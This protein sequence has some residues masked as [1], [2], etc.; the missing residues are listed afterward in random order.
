M[1]TAAQLARFE[2]HYS[3]EPNSGCWLWFGSRDH[4]GYGSVTI[5]KRSHRSHRVAYE[6]FKGP[7]PVGLV[8]D[9]LCRVTSCVNPDHLEP[10]TC[11]VNLNR[12][13]H[14]NAVK[15]HCVRGHAFDRVDGR[16]SRRCKTCAT[17]TQREYRRRK[18]G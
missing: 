14:R 1:M 12:G 13:I 15:A 2:R 10:V 16:G 17:L 3:P 11:K 7:I 5:D 8:L 4:A 6:H 18:A 9:H